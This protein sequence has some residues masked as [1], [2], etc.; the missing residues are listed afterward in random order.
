MRA[1]SERSS[2]N[3]SMSQSTA[4][5]ESQQ[6]TL[7]TSGFLAPPFKVSAT[8]M[9]FESWIP[10][11]FCDFVHAPLMPLVAFVE[12]PPQKG[13][14]SRRRALPPCSKMVWHAEKP[15][16]PPPTTIACCAGKTHAPEACCAA[17]DICS[18]TI[19]LLSTRWGK[20]AES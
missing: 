4:G 18:E 14:L 9:S 3:L 12:L 13:L 6:S 17:H 7:A 5:P 11:F 1:I 16:R 19:Q 15:E 20:R 10:S 8:K 2:S